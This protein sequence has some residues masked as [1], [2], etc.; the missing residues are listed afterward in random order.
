MFVF[1]YTVN[2]LKLTHCTLYTMHCVHIVQCTRCTV[3]TLHVLQF[4]PCVVRGLVCTVSRALPPIKGKDWSLPW[5]PSSCCPG[6]RAY[7]GYLYFRDSCL[8]TRMDKEQSARL[9]PQ[10]CHLPFRDSYM[11]TR[12][13][14]EQSAGLS[15][16]M[17]T[18]F[19]AGEMAGVRSCVILTTPSF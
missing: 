9:K 18:I 6:R 3:Y 5:S 11:L 8:L 14:M 15:L 17:A 1:L 7:H 19:L 10:K 2:M 13:D 4:V 16:T 12:M